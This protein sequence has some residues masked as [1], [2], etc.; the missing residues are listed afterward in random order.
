MC[1]G[2]HAV[3]QFQTALAMLMFSTFE[4]LCSWMKGGFFYK[5]SFDDVALKIGYL[6]LCF[7]LQS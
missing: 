5:V 4:L 1:I 2:I 6:L 7:T 3:L